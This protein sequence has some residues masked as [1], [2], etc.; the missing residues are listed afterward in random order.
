MRRR[1]VSSEKR[2]IRN[3]LG[4][5]SKGNPLTDMNDINELIK[6]LISKVIERGLEANL[7]ENLGYSK[8][9]YENKSIDK[10][11]NGYPSKIKIQGK[12]TCYIETHVKDL[13]G[14]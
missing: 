3:L 1:N 5:F 12:S 10:S 14:I 8:Y 9:D 2:R 11:R 7:E 6:E 4:Q 13:Y